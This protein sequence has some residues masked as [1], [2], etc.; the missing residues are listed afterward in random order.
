MLDAEK[1]REKHLEWYN[2]NTR[3][4]N[5]NDNVV[6]ID[7]PFLDNFSD[8]IEMYAVGQKNGLIELTDDG[9]TLDNLLSRGVDINKSK[10][11]KTIL[12]NQL[13][14]YGIS[15]IDD[16]LTTTVNINH[17]AEAKNRNSIIKELQR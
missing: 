8:E 7:V 6:A 4:E 2:Q 14:G 16:E 15:L 13:R 5:L 12:I 3:F 1:L 11:R 10:K 9:W 17:F